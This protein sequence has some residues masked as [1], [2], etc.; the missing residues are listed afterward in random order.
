MLET[1]TDRRIARTK[2]AIENT[3]LDL[4]NHKTL[5]ALTINDITDRANINRSTFYEYFDDKFDLFNH[6][7]RKTFQQK[8]LEHLPDYGSYSPENISKL[9]QATA[10]YFQ[11]LNAQCPPTERVMRPIAE[12]QVQAVLYEALICWFPPEKKNEPGSK[13][14]FVS[15]AIFGTLLDSIANGKMF[16]VGKITKKVISLSRIVLENESIVR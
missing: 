6:I 2:E 5:Q 7:V 10:E 16:D 1:T 9:V 12:A 15:W 14:L 4:L 8:V 3:F 11:Y 13:A